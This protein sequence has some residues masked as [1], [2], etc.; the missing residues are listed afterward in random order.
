MRRILLVALA[1]ALPA[2][3]ASASKYTD[4]HQTKDA[5]RQIR[6]CTRIIE[7]G[8]KEPRKNRSIAYFSRGVAYFGKGETDRAISDF[9]EAI[10]LNP[11]YTSVYWARGHAYDTKGDRD[12]AIAD[13]TKA[14]ALNPKDDFV[15]SAR[16]LLYFKGG[17]FDRAIGDLTKAIEIKP[18][19]R[20]YFN[21]GV[22]YI[23]KGDKEHAT[24][25]LRSA[26]AIDSSFPRAK[27]TLAALEAVPAAAKA[28]TPPKAKE[29]R[30]KALQ[31]CASETPAIGL[32]GCT[33]I[34]ERGDKET[35]KLRASA[36]V[37]RGKHY[38]NQSDY[39]HAIAD[40]TKAIELDPKFGDAYYLR[41]NSYFAQGD[42]DRAIADETKAIELDPKRSSAYW[43]R[44]KAYSAKGL[45]HAAGDESNEL[46]KRG[47]SDL[48]KVIELDP[49]TDG[50]Y[51]YRGLVYT[52][53]FRAFGNEKDK[54]LAVA[55]FRKALEINPSSKDAQS[56][57]SGLESASSTSPE[58]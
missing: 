45:N 21:R 26:L 44:G 17:E 18:S 52:I 56:G 3:G 29:L 27:E 22:A 46:V 37:L 15:Y 58:R 1:V 43:I 10:A 35:A 6:G 9:N 48:N 16:G 55:S 11:K 39:Q 30:E 23:K 38:I 4:C 53:L 14:I 51:V 8:K 57:L 19:A 54:S 2:I 49:N 42:Y 7:R 50:A 12:Q 20:D 31:D 28:G 25:D 5:D 33:E 24:A 32:R 41:G 40:L 36:Y 13:F 47:I 34:I